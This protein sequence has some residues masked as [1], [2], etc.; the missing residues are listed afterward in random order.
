MTVVMC[1][2]VSTSVLSGFVFALECVLG[3]R[4]ADVVGGCA[5]VTSIWVP[6]PVVDFVSSGVCFVCVTTQSCANP[7]P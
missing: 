1:V 7:L 5:G 6:M 3:A 2:C 4:G